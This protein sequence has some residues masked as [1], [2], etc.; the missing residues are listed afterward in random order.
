MDLG[1]VGLAAEEV[2]GARQAQA[3]A[4]K[5]SQVLA[6][7]HKVC[8]V[9]VG[10]VADREDG[11]CLRAVNAHHIQPHPVAYMQKLRCVKLFAACL[12]P[13]FDRV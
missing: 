4:A 11:L 6:A 1:L 9:A 13:V 3:Q 12:R 10:S 8:H 5:P 7:L 2:Q